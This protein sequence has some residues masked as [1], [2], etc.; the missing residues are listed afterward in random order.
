LDDVSQ[1]VAEFRPD[2]IETVTDA[3]LAAAAPSPGRRAQRELPT[4]I[5]AVR[6][7]IVAIQVMSGLRGWLGASSN[8]VIV[9]SSVVD[10]LGSEPITFQGK[11]HLGIKDG[12]LLPLGPANDPTAVF[13]VY[14][15]EGQLPRTLAFSLLVI[16]SNRGIRDIGSAISGA[17]A[18]LRYKEL[19]GLVTTA[20]TAAVPVYGTLLQVAQGSIGLIADY[21]KAKPDDQLGY[22]QVS[23]TNRFD[24]LGV[25]RHP[26][27]ARTF[28]V[29]KIMLAYQLDAS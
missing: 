22:Y 3:D 18:D 17:I 29:G 15:R 2:L 13:T 11:P 8:G 20:V 4:K 5:T 19:S 21:L 9:V 28:A 23:Y 6:L 12:D 7:Q 10:G 26:A 24:D 25:G 14:Y 1:P 16:R 27:S